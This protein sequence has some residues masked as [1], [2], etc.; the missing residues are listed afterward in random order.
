MGRLALDTFGIIGYD[1]V[2]D[3]AL[4]TLTELRHEKSAWLFIQNGRMVLG[5]A[6]ATVPF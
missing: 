5:K 3:A 6:K 1:N 4:A 2:C